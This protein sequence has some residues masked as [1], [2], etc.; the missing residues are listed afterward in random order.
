MK[1]LVVL[2]LAM[3]PSGLIGQSVIDRGGFYITVAPSEGDV[4]PDGPEDFDG[5]IVLGGSQNAE[6]DDAYPHFIPLLDLMRRFDAA[7]KPVLGICLGSQLLARAYGARIETLPK[8]E[9]GFITVCKTPAAETDFLFREAPREAR[10]MSWHEDVFNLPE[11]STLLMTEDAAPNQAF[12]VGNCSYGV[13]FHPEVTPDII[14]GW[15][16]AEYDTVVRT[17]PDVVASIEKQMEQYMLEAFRL[18]RLIANRWLD[19]VETGRGK[20]PANQTG[21][22]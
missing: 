21:V 22:G 10:V 12:R 3:S 5:M 17:H 2:H 1:I 16:R 15:F 9:I 7:M 8:A 19:L 4:L 20:I 11:N 6:Q 14:R 18:G 13:Q